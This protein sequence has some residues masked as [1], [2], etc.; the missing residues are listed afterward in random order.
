MK[1]FWIGVIAMLALM[2][3]TGGP[4][5]WWLLDKKQTCSHALLWP[6]ALRQTGLS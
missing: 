4:Y 1:K 6:W 5:L 2:D 3:V